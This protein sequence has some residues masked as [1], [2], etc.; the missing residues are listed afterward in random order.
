MAS[1]SVWVRD[2]EF[3]KGTAVYD[4]KVEKKDSKLVEKLYKQSNAEFLRQ[5]PQCTKEWFDRMNGK[6]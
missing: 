5:Y 6:D 2:I 4:A 1:R 3:A